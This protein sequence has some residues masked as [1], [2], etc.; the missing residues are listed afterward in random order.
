MRPSRTAPCTA[1]KVGLRRMCGAQTSS[2]GDVS[3]SS[4]S[5]AA[6]PSD[7]AIGFSTSTCLPASSAAFVNAPC[8]FMLVR[9]RTTSTSSASV[10][11][12][13]SRS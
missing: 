9:T 11:A 3:A 10:T 2:P 7:V 1:R 13:G 12:S 4:R 8:S 5:S 6:S